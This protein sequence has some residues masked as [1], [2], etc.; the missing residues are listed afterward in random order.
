ML[1]SDDFTGRR[2]RIIDKCVQITLTLGRR[3]LDISTGNTGTSGTETVSA[4]E[5]MLAEDAILNSPKTANS[6]ISRIPA[7][8]TCRAGVGI[9]TVHG[10]SG[11]R[12]EFIRV[13]YGFT[14]FRATG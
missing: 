3:Q 11:F 8:T 1:C 10:H 9:L 14:G 7:S 13:I 12:F 2:E 6:P 4:H 5:R